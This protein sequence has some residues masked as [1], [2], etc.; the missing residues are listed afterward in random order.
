[1]WVQK[2]LAAMTQDWEGAVPCQARHMKCVSAA[3]VNGWNASDKH[4]RIAN[5]LLR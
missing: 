1:M 2:Y 5:V 3:D 4:I